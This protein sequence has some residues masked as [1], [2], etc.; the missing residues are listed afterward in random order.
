MTSVYED[1]TLLTTDVAIKGPCR[2]ATTANIV[3]N[4]LQTVDGIALAANDRVLVKNQT[5]G[6]GNG[7]YLASS[8]G[9]TRASDFD[10]N[11]DAVD[12]TLVFVRLGS[13]NILSLYKLTCATT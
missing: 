5:S 13:S 4:G 6:S 9:W 7:I 10:G 12:G 3:L 8:S 1:R 11:R 2:A